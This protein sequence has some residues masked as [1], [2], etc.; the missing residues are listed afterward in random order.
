MYIYLFACTHMY[1]G[2][3]VCT[4]MCMH[5]CV[6][7]NVWS[8]HTCHG[9]HVQVRGQLLRICSLL[10]LCGPQESNSNCR[11]GHKSCLQSYFVRSTLQIFLLESSALLSVVR[12]GSTL[13][14]A[15]GRTRLLSILVKE[16]S[17]C[18]GQQSTQRCLT[19]QR[20][21]NKRP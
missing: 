8:G 11:L 12:N 17:L 5:A 13:H 6:C 20:S 14:F 4:C 7:V 1:A 2:M 3:C 18:S 21:E 10:P 15:G 19:G 9:V 16:A